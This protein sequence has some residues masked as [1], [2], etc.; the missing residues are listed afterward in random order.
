MPYEC[1]DNEESYLDNLGTINTIND[2]LDCTCISI[3][4]ERNSDISDRTS[5]F[6]NHVRLFYTENN[7]IISSEHFLPDG[8]FTHYSEA[9]H[10]TSWLD[11]CMSTNDANEIIINMSAQQTIYHFIWKLPHNVFLKLRL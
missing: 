6:G 1:R 4:G 9:W 7:L 10:N 11:H 8:T 2:E 3:L 5:L